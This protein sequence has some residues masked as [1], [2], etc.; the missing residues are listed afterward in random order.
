MIIINFQMAYFQFKC[1]SYIEI[2]I[3]NSNWKEK[4]SRDLK[5][6]PVHTFIVALKL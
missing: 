3:K 4:G 6:R 5:T 1:R 2:K